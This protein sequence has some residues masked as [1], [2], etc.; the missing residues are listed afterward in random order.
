M[1]PSG[2]S[3]VDSE[4]AKLRKQVEDRKRKQKLDEAKEEIAMVKQA[5]NDQ[6]ETMKKISKDYKS[7]DKVNSKQQS[8]PVQGKHLN[9]ATGKVSL[10]TY[11]AQEKIINRHNSNKRIIINDSEKRKSETM[12]KL[13][14]QFEELNPT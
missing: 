10:D 6:K 2:S 12:N 4:G 3:V 14:K 13:K 5:K 8:K 9:Y 7:L 1:G 11:T